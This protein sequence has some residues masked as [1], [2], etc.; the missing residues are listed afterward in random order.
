MFK[1][2]ILIQTLKNKFH[3]ELFTKGFGENF[4]GLHG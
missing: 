2:R 1:T 4:G 3:F